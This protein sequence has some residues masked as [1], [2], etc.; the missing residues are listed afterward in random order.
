MNVCCYLNKLILNDNMKRL[1]VPRIKKTAAEDI[2]T[3][4][5]HSL[6]IKANE[7]IY[8]KQNTNTWI[9]AVRVT[10]MHFIL[11]SFNK[12][13]DESSGCTSERWKYCK[14]SHVLL[15]RLVGRVFFTATQTPEFFPFLSRRPREGRR[16]SPGKT[17]RPSACSETQRGA[18]RMKET[19]RMK[20]SFQEQVS[21]SPSDCWFPQ[22]TLR[23]AS[24]SPQSPP[25]A[26]KIKKLIHEPNNFLIF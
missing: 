21:V 16:R 17:H 24:P 22:K 1:Y 5:L 6:Q 13:I 7:Y 4:V 19:Q 9:N 14:R 20:S 23:S 3:G 11:D 25:S 12:Y 15:Q 26:N 8:W 2:K 10:Y 18:E